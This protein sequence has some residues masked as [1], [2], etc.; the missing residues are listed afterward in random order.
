MNFRNSVKSHRVSFLGFD[1][2]ND[3]KV[4]PQIPTRV[5]GYSYS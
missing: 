5:Y 4:D 3:Y 1:T 2:R